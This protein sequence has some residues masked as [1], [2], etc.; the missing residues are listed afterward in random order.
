M[1]VLNYPAIESSAIS[2]LLS[3]SVEN[4]KDDTV[5]F[6][7]VRRC[8][9]GSLQNAFRYEYLHLFYIKEGAGNVTDEV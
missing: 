9:I 8:T 1:R 7:S 3:I 4:E 2:S 5:Q 6:Y